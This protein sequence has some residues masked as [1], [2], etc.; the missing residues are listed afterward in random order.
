[1]D[2]VAAMDMI[3]ENSSTNTINQSKAS[4]I[5]YFNPYM[6][7]DLRLSMSFQVQKNLTA[8]TQVPGSESPLY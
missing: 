3:E 6:F 4:N 7:K 5:E 8:R 2:T 1:M